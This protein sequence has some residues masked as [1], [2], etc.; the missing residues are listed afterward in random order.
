MQVKDIASDGLIFGMDLN[1]PRFEK[2]GWKEQIK[3]DAMKN[4]LHTQQFDAIPLVERNGGPVSG[5]ARRRL[6][7]GEEDDVYFLQLNDVKRMLC[8]DS[9]LDALFNIIS[10]NNSHHI[11]LLYDQSI[12]KTRPT[13]ILTIDMLGNELVRNY[14]ILK[15]AEV[16]SHEWNEEKQLLRINESYTID[17]GVNIYNKILE[18]S[19]LVEDN[20]KP[21]SG[22]ESVKSKCLE[23]LELLEPLKGSPK[24]SVDH[25]DYVKPTKK[26]TNEAKS[27]MC[28]PMV[29]LKYPQNIQEDGEKIS[30][31][32]KLSYDVAVWSLSYANDFDHILIKN[33]NY[34]YDRTYHL[35]SAGEKPK[36]NTAVTISLAQIIECKTPL[37]KILNRLTKEP[38][39]SL[40]VEPDSELKWPGV[41]TIHDLSNNSELLWKYFR[42][43][44]EIEIYLRRF[45]IEKKQYQIRC[46]NGEEKPVNIAELNW[47]LK[48]YIN[49]RNNN[50]VKIT[51]NASWKFRRGRN[52]IAHALIGFSKDDSG[53]TKERKLQRYQYDEFIGGINII[54]KLHREIS[55]LNI[56]PESTKNLEIVTAL[57]YASKKKGV[58]KDITDYIKKIYEEENGEKKLIISVKDAPSEYIKELNSKNIRLELEDYIDWDLEFIEI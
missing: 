18:L 51:S 20:I 19:K 13:S 33:Q 11:V 39:L 58:D 32:E 15:M 25:E 30:T 56:S 57:Q 55:K 1:S 36:E 4:I 2:S 38:E 26:Y 53:N 43:A 6:H 46:R 28:W 52:L 34:G 8:S 21:I 9:I 24:T 5:V 27:L 37:I 22:E 41:I 35:I 45:M 29:S 14:L 47:I 31:E 40:V 10:N 16:C 12:T 17:Y 54:D 50:D 49:L 23:I 3:I 44:V 42:Y 48:E 7:D